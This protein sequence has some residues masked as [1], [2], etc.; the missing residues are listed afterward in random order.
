MLMSFLTALFEP[1]RFIKHRQER[2][3]YLAQWELRVAT[4]Q[5]EQALANSRRDQEHQLKLAQVFMDGLAAMH[6]AQR[7]AATSSA[8]GM[9]AIA[10]AISSQAESFGAWVKLFQTTSAPTSSS[11]VTDEDELLKQQM[12]LIDAGMPAELADLPEELRLAWTLKNDPNFMDIG[13]NTV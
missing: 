11:V 1:F 13:P 12:L 10:K 9:A 8:D 5:A 2:H 3:D 7:D 6:D 4:E